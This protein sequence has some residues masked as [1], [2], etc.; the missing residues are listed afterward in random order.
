MHDRIRSSI[1]SVLP[2]KTRP[3]RILAGHIKGSWIFTSWH[4]YPGAIT[5]RTER[6]LLRWFAQEINKG[7]TWL[8]VG[9]HYGYTAIALS[10]FVESAGRVYAFEP[11]I[12]SAGCLVQTRVKNDLQQ[13]TVV[14]FGLG[15]NEDLE[16]LT[17]PC[18]RGMVDSTI[19]R[20]D[21]LETFFVAR[22]DWLW[23][24]LCGENTTV[25]GIKIDVQGMEIDVLRGMTNI[26][27]TLKPKLIVELHKGVDRNEFLNLIES[28]GYS[29]EAIPVNEEQ[30]GTVIRLLDDESYLFLPVQP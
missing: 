29:S 13:L 27:Q 30:A 1:R 3:Y 5:G 6:S 9:A 15:G 26:L 12:S 21:W 17:L 7:E 22:L 28:A 4:D 16:T 8:D 25:D 10:K 23:P 19:E 18:V 14:P 24:S 11:S 2:R 20:S